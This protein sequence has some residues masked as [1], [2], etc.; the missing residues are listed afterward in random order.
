MKEGTEIGAAF[1]FGLFSVVL[2]GIGYS[3]CRW[4]RWDG[5]MNC[6][7]GLGCRRRGWGEIDVNS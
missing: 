1:G 5:Y 3:D 2:K 7:E 6:V 4:L